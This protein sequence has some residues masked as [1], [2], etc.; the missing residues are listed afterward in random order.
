MKQTLE[1]MTSSL[2]R[3]LII[4]KKN[5]EAV[6]PE[7]LH[8]VYRDSYYELLH[9]IKKEAEQ[10]VK[11]VT[12]SNLIINPKVSL[13]KQIETINRT[14]E[15]SGLM[16]DISRC[17]FRYYD[18]EKAYPLCARLRRQ[19]DDALLLYIT[20]ENTP[21]DVPSDLQKKLL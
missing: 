19:I 20:R 5:R 14:I 11:A 3:L 17:F 12:L 8:T 7:L 2:N 9:R 1:Q 6:A 10:F 13:D 4:L 18:L 21:S 16:T 15:D